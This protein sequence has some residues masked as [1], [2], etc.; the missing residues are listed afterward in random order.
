M[1]TFVLNLTSSAPP[2]RLFALLHDAPG[3]SQWF[4]PARRVR[5]MPGHPAGGA[6]AVR[7]VTIGPVTVQETVVEEVVPTLHAYSI[8]TVLPVCDHRADVHLVPDG[9]GTRIEWSTAFR[10]KLPG[11]GALLTAGL[12]FGVR[13]LAAALI[14]AAEGR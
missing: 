5:W 9:S 3:W 13:G 14:K 4:G 7:L 10:P 2:E 1:H 11:T 6:G 8:R 12:R